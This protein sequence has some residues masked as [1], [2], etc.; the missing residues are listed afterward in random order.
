MEQFDKEIRLPGVG[1]MNVDII[2]SLLKPE[3]TRLLR[4]GRRF[5]GL[6]GRT[7]S[8]RNILGNIKIE[9]PYNTHSELAEVIGTA[10]D[11]EVNGIIFFI[12]D[13]DPSYLDFIMEYYP[14]T[15]EVERVLFDK[16]DFKLNFSVDHRI[17]GA[18]VI[19][20]LLYWNDAYNPLR[21][22]N[23][24][25]LRGP[26]DYYDAP[27][28]KQTISLIKY[29]PAFSILP[30]YFTDEDKQ[31]NNLRGKLFQFKCSYT[32]DD[33]EESVTGPTSKVVIPFGDYDIIGGVI[34]SAKNNNAIK[35]SFNTG[36]HTVKEINIFVRI[37][38]IGH[39]GKVETINKKDNNYHNDTFYEYIFYNDRFSTIENQ[40]EINQSYSAIPLLADSLGYLHTNNLIIGGLTEGYDNLT[41][42]NVNYK[43]FTYYVDP[44]VANEPTGLYYHT[45]TKVYLIFPYSITIRFFTNFTT[46]NNPEANNILKIDFNGP[47]SNYHAEV[48]VSQAMAANPELT[49]EVVKEKI[50][51]EFAG[52][53]TAYTSLFLPG[54]GEQV[55]PENAIAILPGPS[56]GSIT[57]WTIKHSH[58]RSYPAFKSGANHPFGIVYY[59]EEGRHC[60]VQDAGTAYCPFLTEKSVDKK[61]ASR[62]WAINWEINH[63]PP[64][65]ARYYRWVYSKQADILSFRQYVIDDILEGTTGDNY[66]ITISGGTGNWTVGDEIEGKVSGARAIITKIVN[67]GA[68]ATF[69][70]FY[71]GEPPTNFDGSEGIQNNDDT[72]DSSGSGPVSDGYI[73]VDPGKMGIDITSLNTHSRQ[74]NEMGFGFLNSSIKP[75]VFQKGDRI[76]FITKTIDN[77][78][79]DG[80]GDLLGYYLDLEILDYQVLPADP[81]DPDKELATNTIIVQWFDAEDYPNIGP[82]TLVEIYTPS[83][84]QEESI[85]FEFGYNYDILN[86]YTD[87]RVHAGPAQNQYIDDAGKLQPAKGR[88]EHGDVYVVPT[89][90]NDTFDEVPHN[91]YVNAIESMSASNFYDHDIHSYGKPHVIDAKAETKK[92]L[93][94]RMSR[95]Y[96]E[97]TEINGLSE[98]YGNA[99]LFV[100]AEF[101]DTIT[102][103]T[104]VGFTLKVL[105]ERKLTSFFVGRTGLQLAS[106]QDTD[107]IVADSSGVSTKSPAKEARGCSNHESVLSVGR[108]LFFVD[109]RNGVIVRDAANG[110][111][112]IEKYGIQKDIKEICSKLLTDYTSSRILASHNPVTNEVGFSFVGFND[113]GEADFGTYYFKY[114]NNEWSNIW[115]YGLH[116]L[117]PNNFASINQHYVS[118][119]GADVWLHEKN[120]LRNNFY[121]KQLPLTVEMIFNK[122][123]T[124]LFK[125]VEIIGIGEWS[126][127]EI[128]D[129]LIEAKNS[130]IN[131]IQKSRIVSGRFKNVKGKKVAY[132]LKDA[133][134]QNGINQDINLHNG[135][136]LKGSI[137][138]IRLICNDDTEALIDNVAVL[139]QKLLIS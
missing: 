43:P 114:E 105:Q 137:I 63:I 76:R 24:R 116:Q 86:P 90:F 99:D 1:G 40:I 21:K 60:S 19:D 50:N 133:N 110:M 42:I 41:E 57:E 66:S 84:T 39:W 98:F 97:G 74:N 16:G 34:G 18:F 115:D 67:P 128:G 134:T 8:V 82:K 130:V 106:G 88:F 2:D 93:S 36:H 139:Y 64:K 70:Y 121:G 38:N 102:G 49:R 25:K 96:F 30:N 23:L 80:I 55:V 54:S 92:N 33:N 9:Y 111:F 124:K 108:Q 62:R 120:P 95:K 68:T 11:D 12:A 32:Y 73:S 15:G 27:P 20:G 100:S 29:P 107:Q 61:L 4:N 5:D 28:D 129:V 103:L 138:F 48:F 52:A 89:V 45:Y 91:Y 10:R 69:H 47:L 78:A 104:E 65:W 44:V 112:D 113:K 26:V 13:P 126:C 22:V 83:L 136:D 125:V 94:I 117:A 72:G 56:S 6:D 75:Y 81:A 109:I 131:K 101:G 127:P 85:Y 132:F 35:F 122:P 135:K 119:I 58:F 7:G 51:I 46:S 77:L 31:A 87:D 123:G 17:K 79:S 37:G 71:I 118:F 53:F 59:E 14:D 3:N